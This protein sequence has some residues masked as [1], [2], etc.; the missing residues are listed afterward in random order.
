MTAAARPHRRPLLLASFA[1]LFACEDPQS[2]RSVVGIQAKSAFAGSAWS[3]PVHLDA[4]VNSACQDQ[5]PTLSKD[6]LSLYFTSTRRGGL[7][8]DTPDGCQDTFDLWVAQRAS[9]DSPWETA[10]NLG[11]PVNTPDQEAGPALSHDGRLLFFYRFV[12]TGQRDIYVT[13]RDP[14]DLTWETPVSL[15]LDVNTESLE[16]GP[17]FLQHEGDGDA[18]LYFDRGASPVLTDIHAVRVTKDGAT[19]GPAQAVADLNSS[20][21]DNHA[22]IRRDGR[23]IFFNSRRPGGV[24]NPSGQPSFDIWVATRGNVHDAWSTPVN[25][26]APVNSRFA[27]FHANIS[28]DGRT[29]LFIAPVARGGLG[30]F[31]IW[32]TTRTQGAN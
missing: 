9:R 5:T 19:L 11:S 12:G 30:G 7:G 2:Y 32:M 3:E 10:V 6:E 1:F 4:P 14:N 25:L 28:F 18:T 23:E 22:S 29:L 20:V 8:N 15:G 21:E 13:R 24:P 17:T 31:D 27:E 16:E 26:G